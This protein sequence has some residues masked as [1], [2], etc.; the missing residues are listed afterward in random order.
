MGDGSGIL[1]VDGRGVHMNHG[2]GVFPITAD[3]TGEADWA[4]IGSRPGIGGLLGC[5]GIPEPITSVGVR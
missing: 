3:G 1:S 2:D 5:T 4:G